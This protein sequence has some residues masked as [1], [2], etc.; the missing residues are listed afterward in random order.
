MMTA[1]G[2][3]GVETGP[4]LETGAGAGVTTGA[5]EGDGVGVV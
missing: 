5:T 2:A 3:I 1:G 4:A